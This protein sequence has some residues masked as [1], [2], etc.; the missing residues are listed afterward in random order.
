MTGMRGSTTKYLSKKNFLLIILLKK[1]NQLFL[2]CQRAA[3]G[4]NY[5]KNAPTK[6]HTKK[7]LPF[8]RHGVVRIL[9]NDTGY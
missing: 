2:N 7:M 4:P 1:N 9:F 3:V 5:A 6:Y 8:G